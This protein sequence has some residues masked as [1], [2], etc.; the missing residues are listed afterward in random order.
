MITNKFLDPFISKQDVSKQGG[1]LIDTHPSSEMNILKEDGLNS[2][3]VSAGQK[4]KVKK[5]RHIY[6]F[7]A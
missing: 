3:T 6:C 4:L 1:G 7:I 2:T 5:V